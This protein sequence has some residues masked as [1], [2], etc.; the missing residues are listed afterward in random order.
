[1]RATSGLRA[2][3]DANRRASKAIER[4]LPQAS[5][6][7]QREYERLV[8]EY[9][10]ARP[11]QLVVDVGGGKRCQFAKYRDEGNGSRIVAVDVDPAELEANDDVDEKRVADAARELPFGDGEVDIVASR[12]VLEHLPQVGGFLDE[13]YRVLRP[14]GYTIHVF[15]SKWAPF[16]LAN[17][18]L[19]RR[20]SARIVHTMIPGSKGRLGFPAYYD[21]TYASGMRRALGAAGFEVVEQRVSYYQAEYF[22]FLFPLYLLNALYELVVRALGLEDLGATVL[23]VGRKPSA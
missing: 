13:A 16:S 11:G 12:S 20:L 4:R 18:A 7:V 10:N 19:P 17:R 2:F 5:T 6:N 23:I 1:V 3:L 15:P 21:R 9:L 22:T 14:G 8:G